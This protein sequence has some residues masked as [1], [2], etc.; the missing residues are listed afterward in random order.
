MP[1]HYRQGDVLLVAHPALP[2]GAVA[3]PPGPL[4]LAEGEHTGHFHAVPAAAAVRGFHLADSLW[5]ACTQP[6]PV[7]HPDHATIVLPPG[8]FE[9]RQ[10]RIYLYAATPAPD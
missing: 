7:E 5:L 9:V 3:L 10:Q 8:V 2:A 4:V 6:T 1:I